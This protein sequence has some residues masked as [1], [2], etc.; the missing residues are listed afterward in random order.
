VENGKGKE[1]TSIVTGMK[2]QLIDENLKI[3][4]EHKAALP[5]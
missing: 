5:P 2:A 4:D 3:I 1:E